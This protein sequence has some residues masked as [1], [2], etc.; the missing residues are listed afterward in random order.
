MQTKTQIFEAMDR[1]LAS[2]GMTT[3]QVDLVC[4][5][6]GTAKVPFIQK[7]L[8]NRFGKEKLQTQAHFHSV[9]GGLVEAAA[10][11]ANGLTY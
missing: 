8:E 3:D 5:T 2:A 1:C 7:E 4:L 11:R 10:F 9:L 6:G